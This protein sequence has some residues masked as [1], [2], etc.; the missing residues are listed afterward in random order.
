MTTIDPVHEVSIAQSKIE[1]LTRI[2]KRMKDEGNPLNGQ[3]F[4]ENDIYDFLLG[5]TK[6]WII[7]SA[8]MYQAFKD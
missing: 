2:A 5:C 1:Q 4:I 3:P 7:T 6:D 8:I